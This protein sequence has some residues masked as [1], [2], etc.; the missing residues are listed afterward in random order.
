SREISPEDR[1]LVNSIPRDSRSLLGHF[2]LHPRLRLFV[3]CPSCFSLYDERVICPVSC[4]SKETPTSAPCGAALT[5]TRQIGSKHFERPIR[6]Y[7]HQEMGEW[8]GRLLSRPDIE[9]SLEKSCSEEAFN[10]DGP[11]RDIA[12]AKIVQNFLGSD[13]KPFMQPE[14][15]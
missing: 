9:K 13:G 14:G 8:V 6:K 10:G 7:A 3:C 12:D 15:N 2:D 11:W 5:C 1:V 4:T